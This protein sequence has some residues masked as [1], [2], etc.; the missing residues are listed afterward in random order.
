LAKAEEIRNRVDNECK[1]KG[2]AAEVRIDGSLAKDTWLREKADIDIFMRVSPQ[3][4][5]EQLKDRC[6]PIAKMAL[7]PNK[8]VE[9]YAEHPYVE[10]NVQ[11]DGHRSVRV[12]VVPCYNVKRGQ[13]LSATDRS[14]Y[15]TEYMVL[16][17]KE[18]QR[19]EVR[20]LK[21]FL[22]GVGSY[23]ADI[24]TGGF[25][26]MLC[27]TLV[28]S[29]GNFRRVVEEFATWQHERFIDLE[30][31]YQ[32]RVDEVR[33]IFQE[34]LIVIDPVD[35]GRNL[36]AAVREEQLWN[37][38]AACRHLLKKPTTSLFSEPKTRPLSK[39]E[40]QRMLRAKRST[41]LCV[42]VGRI[43]AVVDILWSQLYRTERAL[44]TLLSTNDF[45][46][47]RSLAWSDEES[48]NVILLSLEQEELTPSKKHLGPPVSR[49]TESSSFLTKHVKNSRTVSGPWIENER[50]VVERRRENTSALRLLSTSLKSGGKEIGVASLLADRFR[51]R[52]IILADESIGRLISEEREFAKAMRVYMAGRPTWLDK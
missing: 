19:D 1:Q 43:D 3:L 14:P 7:L 27:E 42:V 45:K 17:L 40:F 20:L 4:T 50:W 6:L 8:I 10:S 38:V 24:K 46:V 39:A 11:L 18:N 48:L 49:A 2:L 51:K 35:K 5:K 13:W 23:G 41:L 12:N 22:R 21:A 28:V 33:R 52:T 36:G 32:D 47:S 9:R 25:S 30:G 44:V 37:F 29:L 31:F 26:G 15:H 16:H 34:P